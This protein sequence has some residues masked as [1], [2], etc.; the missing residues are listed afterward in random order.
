MDGS[1]WTLFL[2][3]GSPVFYLLHRRQEERR[4]TGETA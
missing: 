3:T 4:D 2:S 1:Y